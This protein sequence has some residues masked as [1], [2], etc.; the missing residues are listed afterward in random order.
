MLGWERPI[1]AA[2]N[3]IRRL[4]AGWIMRMAT[5]RGVN[6]ALQVIGIERANPQGVLGSCI[7]H[8]TTYPTAAQ[9]CITPVVAFAT[10]SVYRATKGTLNVPSVFY[11]LSLLQLPK[12]FM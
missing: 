8:M 5:I 6:N 3:A 4:E 2:M 12:L 7:C 11:A 9:F 1:A 10:F